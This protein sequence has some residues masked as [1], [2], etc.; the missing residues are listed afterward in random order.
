MNAVP[1]QIST[2]IDAPELETLNRLRAAECPECGT[3]FAIPNCV[4][5]DR[6]HEQRSLFCPS[7]HSFAIQND[8][9]NMG[10]LVLID[11][12]ILTEAE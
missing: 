10:D 11:V 2:S 4:Y 5:M 3:I 6:L 7:G 9:E 12:Q 1:L 8:P